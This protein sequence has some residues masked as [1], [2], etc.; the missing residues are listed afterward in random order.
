M[1]GWIHQKNNRMSCHGKEVHQ[2][3]IG[4]INKNDQM[5][6]HGGGFLAQ[7]HFKKWYKRIY[8]AILDTMMLNALF[9]CNDL[10]TAKNG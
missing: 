5:R 6:L 4:L 10:V 1:P 8:L 3:D 2:E 7:G 9:A